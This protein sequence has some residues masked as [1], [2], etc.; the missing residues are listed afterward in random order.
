MT[1]LIKI[2]YHIILNQ[3]HLLLESVHIGDCKQTNIE[4]SATYAMNR[5]EV[6]KLD[7]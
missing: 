7:E 2:G 1:I 5:Y 3:Q 4:N 6:C